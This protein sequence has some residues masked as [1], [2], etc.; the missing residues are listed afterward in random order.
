MLDKNKKK[1]KGLSELSEIYDLIGAEEKLVRDIKKFGISSS[2][3]I[4]PKKFADKDYF[5][6]LFIY[7]KQIQKKRDIN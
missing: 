3:I 7:P 4:L 5:A 6:K 2:H 1:E